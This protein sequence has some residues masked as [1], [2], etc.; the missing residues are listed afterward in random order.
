MSTLE[1]IAIT[2]KAEFDK[3]QYNCDQYYIIV[4]TCKVKFDLEGL[5]GTQPL[6]GTDV[7]ATKPE[8]PSRKYK[9][10]A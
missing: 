3:G 2:C 8:V 1:R 7:E 5:V 10:S 9:P 6:C 4:S